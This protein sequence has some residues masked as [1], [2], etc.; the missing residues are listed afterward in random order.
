MTAP[1]STGY[2]QSLR[3]LHTVLVFGMLLFVSVSFFIVFKRSGS[4]VDIS[5]DRILQVIAV[6]FTGVSLFIGFRLFNN[7]ILELRRSLLPVRAKLDAYRLACII[8]WAMIEGPALFATVGYFL[9]GNTA[10]FALSLFHI[11][12]LA[13]FMPRR[14][15]F[16]LLLNLKDTEMGELDK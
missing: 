3:L 7:K 5:L 1:R 2:Y 14:D 4:L 13:V 11:A 12:I 8:W 10:F 6:V 16:K 9:T 15:N